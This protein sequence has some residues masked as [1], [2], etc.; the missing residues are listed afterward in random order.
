MS[1]NLED[2]VKA[3]Y[4]TLARATTRD[5]TGEYLTIF[6]KNPVSPKGQNI[7]VAKN[8]KLKDVNYKDFL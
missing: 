2:R 8:V 7:L 4:I 3:G 6:L 1:Y 5:L